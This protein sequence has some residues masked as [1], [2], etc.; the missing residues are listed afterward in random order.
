MGSLA[1]ACQRFFHPACTEEVLEEIIPYINGTSHDSL[2][3]TQY[4]LLSFL[5]LSHPQI[6]LP[7]LFRLWEPVNSKMYASRMINFLAKLAELHVDPT[8][9]DPARIK[10]VPDD[11]LRPCESRINWDK[12]DLA[13]YG[14]WKGIFKDVGIF[15]DE[16]WNI[17]MCYTLSSMGM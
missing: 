16:Q 4:Y 5:P 11:A 9:S 1:E 15:T 10:D 8:V 17:L 3:A 12:S 7:T 14:S 13:S 6:Y 2:L